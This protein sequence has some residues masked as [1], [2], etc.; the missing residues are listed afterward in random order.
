LA[1]KNE[2]NGREKAVEHW[3]QRLLSAAFNKWKEDFIT[4]RRQKA[5]MD[6]LASGRKSILVDM[7]SDEDDNG[8]DDDDDDDDHSDNEGYEGKTLL[9]DSIL[10]SS[11]GAK[12]KAKK[13]KDIL[14]IETSNDGDSLLKELLSDD[15]HSDSDYD[16]DDDDDDDDSKMMDYVA[17][18]DSPTMPMGLRLSRKL[19]CSSSVLRMSLSTSAGSGSGNSFSMA[20]QK[21]GT[22]GLANLGNT[23]YMNSVVQALL[24]VGEWRQFF[25]NVVVSSD[26]GSSAINLPALRNIERRD[27]LDCFTALSARKAAVPA[28]ELSLSLEMHKLMRVLWSGKWRCAT[29]YGFLRAVWHYFPAMANFRQQDAQ[30]FWCLLRDQLHTELAK[31]PSGRTIVSRTFGGTLRSRI[32][33]PRCGHTSDTLTPLL[34]LSLGIQHPSS[35]SGGSRSSPRGS[36]SSALL[37]GASSST[38]TLGYCLARF[39][40]EERIDGYACERCKRSVRASKQLRIVQLPKVLCIVLKRFG[41]TMSGTLRKDS[42]LVRFALRDFDVAPVCADDLPRGALPNTRYALRS[43]VAHHGRGISQGH[44]TAMM[45]CSGDSERFV[46]LDDRKASPIDADSMLP[47]LSSPSLAADL[48]SRNHR[49]SFRL[50]S[51]Y[52]FFYHRQA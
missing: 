23:C 22:V 31:Q 3:R 25:M 33:C 1:Q 6:F 27:T 14:M 37:S 24:A 2:Q 46:H 43:I 5:R 48:A 8:N 39:G 42:S 28:D 52:I 50:G 40:D 13:E 19:S 45:A 36:R 7:S 51:P 15:G 34:E 32:T 18:T 26:G 30:E 44:Y 17:A 35:S 9:T 11:P 41:Y 47:H 49:S 4:E 29:A 16:D 21:P 10:L 38:T 12:A 20:C